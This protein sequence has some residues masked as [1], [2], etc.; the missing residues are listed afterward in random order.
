M[1]SQGLVQLGARQMECQVSIMSSGSGVPSGPEAY[2]WE[3]GQGSGDRGPF[4]AGC[5]PAQQDKGSLARKCH[6]GPGSRV[7]SGKER[8][9]ARARTR[10]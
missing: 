5:R 1:S 2:T 7:V 9:R 4:P 10:A 6:C 3:A 8:A